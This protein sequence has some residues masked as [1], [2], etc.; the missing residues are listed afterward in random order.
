[1]IPTKIKDNVWQFCFLNFGSCVYLIKL[2]NK[3]ILIDTSSKDNSEDLLG[4]LSYLN[5][6]P[7]DINFVLIT[8]HHEDHTGN[9]SLFKNAKIYDFKNINE[10]KIKDIKHLKTPGHTADSLCF[11]YKDILF[12]GD[13]LFLDGGIGRTD[14]PDSNIKDMEKSLKKIKKLNYKILCPGHI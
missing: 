6:K 7:E 3:N 2:K 1:M 11:V 14:F 8:H 13:T 10:F 9:L 4:E 12:S 5:I